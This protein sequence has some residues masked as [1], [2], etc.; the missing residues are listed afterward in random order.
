M[1]FAASPPR[2]E[3]LTLSQLA[4]YDDVL[5]DVL[6]DRVRGH[7]GLGYLASTL[8]K[9]TMWLIVLR[10][11]FGLPFERIDRSTSLREA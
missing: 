4:S 3:R 7:S 9:Q 10:S 11:I 2:E 1:P 6:V 8:L 5:T